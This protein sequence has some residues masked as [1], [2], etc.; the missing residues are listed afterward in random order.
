M[1]NFF[2]FPAWKC[3]QFSPKTS[4]KSPHCLPK[5]VRYVL[6]LVSLNSDL[7][8]ALVTAV[9][10]TTW[11]YT[12]QNYNSTRQCNKFTQE[13]ESETAVCKMSFICLS[14]NVSL[15]CVKSC[16]SSR[17][18]SCERRLWTTMWASSMTVLKK[19][20]VGSWASRSTINSMNRSQ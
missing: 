16:P 13:N 2:S 9:L 14:L 4:Q 20:R 12:G 3:S 19:R 1:P 8:S 7:C 17:F 11:Y 10:Y 15:T 5:R 6:V 18:A